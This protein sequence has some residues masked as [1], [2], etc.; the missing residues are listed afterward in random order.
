MSPAFSYD[1]QKLERRLRR[2]S[3][4]RLFS[5][6]GNS[7]AICS[8]SE[9]D[10]E[11][12]LIITNELGIFLECVDLASS[13]VYYRALQEKL[14]QVRFVLTYVYTNEFQYGSYSDGVD[15]EEVFQYQ[16]FCD[17]MQE[18]ELKNRLV[19]ELPSKWQEILDD[20]EVLKSKEFDKVQ[21]IIPYLSKVMPVII[22]IAS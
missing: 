12:V 17:S 1:V 4:D 22:K 21:C 14:Q 18:R 6:F 9:C 3:R 2:I 7:L 10:F 5:P 20:F 16:T 11:E 8:V 15:I 19:T 13:K